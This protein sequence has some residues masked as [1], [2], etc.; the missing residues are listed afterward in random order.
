MSQVLKAMKELGAKVNSS[1]MRKRSEVMTRAEQRHKLNELVARHSIP[2][3][4]FARMLGINRHTL[5]RIVEE[6]VEKGVIEEVM[7]DSNQYRYTLTHIH[8]L[9]DYLDKPKWSDSF[10][11]PI[12]LCVG[13]LK[14][15]T[16]KTSTAIHLA[17]GM[18]LDLNLRPR[19]LII[20]FDPQGTI[21]R[22][23]M[24]E[25]DNLSNTITAVDLALRDI[26]GEDSIVNQ[27][28]N[29]KG[30]TELDM[31]QSALIQSHIPNLHMMPALPLDSRFDESFYA[32]T[33]AEE[34]HQV[35]SSLAD[36][37]ISELK[38]HYDLIILDTGPH[39]APMTWA[40]AEAAN[41]LLTPVSPRSLDWSATGLY[42]ETLPSFIEREC[43]TGGTNLQWWKVATVNADREHNRDIQMITEIRQLTGP[44]GLSNYIARSP[45][46][47]E[48]AK[49]FVTVYDLQKSTA[50]TSAR[51]IDEA[52]TTAKSVVEEIKFSL[53]TEFGA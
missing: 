23:V 15:G 22:Y 44:D 21:S 48:A 20:D 38:P 41:A 36:K 40:A 14:G 39:N 29:E 46:F 30:L 31:F 34:R 35:L 7:R 13:N 45:A 9:M 12:V 4:E 8:E 32:Q 1:S 42:C 49:N 3:T 52:V 26:E 2:L 25:D 28:M 11:E 5:R 17:A 33:T 6:A 10:K 16:G 47:E 51:K 50:E 53:L 43:P 19:V 24:N 37:V 18:A 27:I